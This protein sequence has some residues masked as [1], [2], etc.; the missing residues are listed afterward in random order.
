MKRNRTESLPTVRPVVARRCQLVQLVLTAL[1]AV[2]LCSCQLTP[3]APGVAGGARAD[4]PPTAPP[5]AQMPV[6]P[7]GMMPGS[8]PPTA[9]GVQLAA[10]A[11]AAL[12]AS[13]WTGQTNVWAEAVGGP[14][15]APACA[16]WPQTPGAAP[17]GAWRPP[18]ISGRWPYNEYLCDGG[19]QGTQVDVMRD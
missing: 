12:P 8:L 7:V 16:S 9:S 1:V 5:A 13:A 18:G 2:T 4:L 6:G 10:Y 3:P 14:C 19:D 15:A 17:P 11:P